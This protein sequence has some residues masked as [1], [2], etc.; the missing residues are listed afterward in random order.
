MFRLK[1]SVSVVLVMFF[2][3]LLEVKGQEPLMD[4]LSRLRRLGANEWVKNSVRHITLDHMAKS[5]SRSPW[6]GTASDLNLLTQIGN[7]NT[8]R[9]AVSDEQLGSGEPLPQIAGLSE[10]SI[11]GVRVTPELMHNISQCK[12]K[13]LTL[14][15]WYEWTTKELQPII[16]MRNLE[17]LSL[18][19][20]RRAIARY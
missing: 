6:R 1:N 14:R 15:G 19:G 13:R 16:E 7:I 2:C 20:V 10:L 17:G 18:H 8:L 11:Y 4:E 12:L 9:L 5:K 3:P